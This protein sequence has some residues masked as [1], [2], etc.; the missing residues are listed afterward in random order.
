[1]APPVEPGYGAVDSS[2]QLP[3]EYAAPPAP[4][5]YAMQRMAA[6]REE[7]LRFINSFTWAPGCLFYFCSRAMLLFLVLAL[8]VKLYDGAVGAL[9]TGETGEHLPAP[10]VLILS[11]IDLAAIFGLLVWSGRVARRRRWEQL[12]WRDYEHFRQDERTWN[13]VGMVG[14]GLQCLILTISFIVGFVGGLNG[15]H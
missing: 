13:I 12:A 10:A 11:L 6:D 4:D 5:Y 14:W 3:P 2:T 15:G 7:Q 1:V 8:I 9:T